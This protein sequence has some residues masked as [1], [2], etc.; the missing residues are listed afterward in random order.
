MSG[1]G[2]ERREPG[3][4]RAMA[5]G[6]SPGIGQGATERVARRWKVLAVTSVAVF[7]ALLD[8]TIVNIAF[9]DIRGSFPRDSL[10]DLSWILNGYNIVFAA[11]LVP[12]GR[13]A[14][15][16]GRKRMFIGGV[17]VFLA[18]SVLCGVSVS[19]VML[20]TARVLQAV[21][22]AILTPT[23]LSLVLPEFPVEQ[24]ATATA[25]WTATGA[26]AAAT[27]PSLGGVLVN[28]Q[29]WR[30]VFFVNLLF[31]LPM[32]I[33]ARRLLRERSAR[34]RWPS[35]KARSGGGHQAACSA[36][37]RPPR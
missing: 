32:L 16:V 3:A 31:G 22:G 20:V 19:V 1:S 23:S 25:L 29:G 34:W 6:A 21:G 17:L 35:S 9:P 11:A 36:R 24:R 12:A 14:D 33:P 10:G 37:S 27:G 7:M 4:R 2:A 5:N 13:L 18:A 28:W 30:A 15:R 26:V 8:V